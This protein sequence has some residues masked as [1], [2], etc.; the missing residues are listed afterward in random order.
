MECATISEIV[1]DNNGVKI[2]EETREVFDD[3]TDPLQEDRLCQP[4]A[5]YVDEP[6][7]MRVDVEEE[8]GF[9]GFESDDSDS[10]D[11]TEPTSSRSYK[12]YHL[13][14]E[15][16]R[17][18]L[19]L[20]RINRDKK[21]HTQNCP[22]KTEKKRNVQTGRFELGSFTKKN[23]TTYHSK[24]Q[25]VLRQ[26]E[27]KELL[28]YVLEKAKK[29]EDVKRTEVIDIVSNFIKSDNRKNPFRNGEPGDKWFTFFRRRHNQYFLKLKP[30]PLSILERIGF[31]MKVL[32]TIF[33]NNSVVRTH[34]PKRHNKKPEANTRK[35][36][37]EKTKTKPR[38]NGESGLENEDKT[39]FKISEVNCSNT[40]DQESQVMDTNE[41]W[42][43]LRKPETV[44]VDSS[45]HV[46]CGK[47][48]EESS[49]PFA[50]PSVREPERKRLKRYKRGVD[51]KKYVCR[52]HDEDPERWNATVPNGVKPFRIKDEKGL[53]RESIIIPDKKLP[54]GWSKHTIKRKSDKKW[55]VLLVNKEGRK[56]RCFTELYHYFADLKIPFPEDTFDFMVGQK[57]LMIRSQMDG[58]IKPSDEESLALEYTSGRQTGQTVPHNLRRRKKTGQN[59]P[60]RTDRKRKLVTMIGLNLQG[61][62]DVRKRFKRKVGQVQP[63]RNKMI[64]T[65]EENKT[66]VENKVSFKVI[67]KDEKEAKCSK[68]PVRKRKLIKKVEPKVQ[69]QTKISQLRIRKVQ[70]DFSG[71]ARDQT[72]EDED[73]EVGK[74]TSITVDQ[75]F[76]KSPLVP[77]SSDAVNT[78][79]GKVFRK[80]YLYQ[81]HM[82]HYH[83]E[84]GGMALMLNV[85]DLARWQ[86]LKTTPRNSSHRSPRDKGQSRKKTLD[87]LEGTTQRRKCTCGEKKSIAVK[88]EDDEKLSFN[89]WHNSATSDSDTLSA[90]ESK[91][92]MMLYYAEMDHPY[93][94]PGLQPSWMLWDETTMSC[95]VHKV[96]MVTDQSCRSETIN[97]KEMPYELQSIV[98]KEEPIIIKKEVEY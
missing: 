1:Q 52:G 67:S 77:G 88:K 2:K 49:D 71:Q 42:L 29:G 16:N 73:E 58:V 19:L 70:L 81:M 32:N 86:T 61:Q 24:K 48:K 63:Q 9:K 59:L 50:E 96:N 78:C 56:F 89:E 79:C 93:T 54:P 43:R 85:T 97:T 18:K 90:D 68:R 57:T 6:V 80:E 76:E 11:F 75:P 44:F 95:D 83:P 15:K 37:S 10:L 26:Q 25:P 38:R 92:H 46:T 8:E 17:D 74:I 33:Y 51:G 45:K 12:G 7:L 30:K 21:V 65:F 36:K 55:D 4:E 13:W 34:N 47:I 69:N 40:L 41:K 23:D 94:K 27:E 60:G 82:K 5:V 31:T 14:L 20:P 66:N 3:I 53:Y 98:V 62:N 39:N 87:P 72:S 35:K 22:D 64:K 84:M 91:K 28:M